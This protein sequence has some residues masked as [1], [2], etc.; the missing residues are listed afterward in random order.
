MVPP[1]LFL[2]RICVHSRIRLFMQSMAGSM[3]WAA[4]AYC[5]ATEDQPVTKEAWVMPYALVI[6]CVGL[7]IFVISRHIQRESKA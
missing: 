5:Q 6:L 4:P 3:L 1:F 2:M 7:G